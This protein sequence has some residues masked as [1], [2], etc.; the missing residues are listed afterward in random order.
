MTASANALSPP[1]NAS[2]TP[3]PPGAL[4]LRVLSAV[5]SESPWFC[6]ALIWSPVLIPSSPLSSSLAQPPSPPSPSSFSCVQSIFSSAWWF[7][8]E[9]SFWLETIMKTEILFPGWLLWV[10]CTILFLLQSDRCC[11]CLALLLCLLLMW[12]FASNQILLMT[13]SL[14]QPFIDRVTSFDAIKD[15]SEAPARWG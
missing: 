15:A 5:P 7:S 10:F 6:A 9:A 1:F 12:Q 14:A 11:C 13:F 3:H 2:L 4:T 8:D